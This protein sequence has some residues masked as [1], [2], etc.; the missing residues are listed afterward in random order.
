MTTVP[1]AYI[2]V[3]VMALVG[4]GFPVVTYIATAFLRPRKDPNDPNM[5]R[6]WLL[7]GYETDQSLYIRRDSTYECGAE[8]VGDAHINFHFQYYWYAIIFLVFD[9]AFMFLAFGGVIAM[10]DGILERPEVYGALATLT[11]FIVLMGL[12]VWH[13]FRRRGRIYI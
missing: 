12:G 3:A 13:V 11:A 5:M 6:S 8:P 4:I 2:A 1:E 9:I 10:Q 7:P